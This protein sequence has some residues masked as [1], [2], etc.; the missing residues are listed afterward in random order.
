MPSPASAGFYGLV[1]G[2]LIGLAFVLAGLSGLVSRA[3][4]L[5][6]RLDAY[7]DL[8]LWKD[9]E[10]A[11][12]RIDIAELSLSRVPSLQL[13]ATRAFEAIENARGRIGTSVLTVSTGVALLFNLVFD[14]R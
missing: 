7:A 12:A 14:D 10:L 8:P 3:L 11:Q 9:V 4:A 2:V 13:R 6:K 5:R 1:A